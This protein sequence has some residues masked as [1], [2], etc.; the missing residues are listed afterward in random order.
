MA[1]QDLEVERAVDLTE[2]KVASV[3]A[4]VEALHER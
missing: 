2:R 1:P 4:L 3:E